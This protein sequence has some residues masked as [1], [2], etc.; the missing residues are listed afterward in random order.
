MQEYVERK[1]CV[2]RIKV[3]D[4]QIGKWEMEKEME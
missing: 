4:M 1:F 2:S 3:I